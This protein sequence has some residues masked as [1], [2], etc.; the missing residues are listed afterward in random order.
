[1]PVIPALECLGQED[2]P[3]F[4]LSLGYI[5]KIKLKGSGGGE[6]VQSVK[7]V[8]DR[9]VVLFKVCVCVLV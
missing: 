1:M 2:H 8:Y 7:Y 9:L 6:T 5:V 4:E 3:K